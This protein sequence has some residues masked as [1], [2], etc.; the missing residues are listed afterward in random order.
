MNQLGLLHKQFGI[1]YTISKY[2][3][4]KQLYYKLFLNINKENVNTFFKLGLFELSAFSGGEYVGLRKIDVL[5]KIM[6]IR[7]YI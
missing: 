2:E 7:G 3:H 6:N 1:D 4:K 5:R